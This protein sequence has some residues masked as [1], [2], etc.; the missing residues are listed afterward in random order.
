MQINDIEFTKREIDVMACIANGRSNKQIGAILGIDYKTVAI[1]IQNIS[2][3]ME[4][5]IN[6]DSSKT[7]L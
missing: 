3:K 6:T 4:K 2:K 5:I 7:R 1:H